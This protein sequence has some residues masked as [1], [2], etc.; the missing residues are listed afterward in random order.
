M[1][2]SCRYQES[3]L[4]CLPRSCLVILK[5]SFCPRGSRSYKSTSIQCYR[6]HSWLAVCLLKDSWILPTTLRIITVQL[7]SVSISC[8]LLYSHTLDF[9]LSYSLSLS[10]SL[11]SR[12]CTEECLHVLSIQSR[13]GNS[14]TVTE[15]RSIAF[16]VT[17]LLPNMMSL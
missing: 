12:Y 17:S 4:I 10:L 13:M 15:H 8:T 11:S 7:V 3:N 16:C 14:S 5:N 2:L 6:I 9:H 1:F